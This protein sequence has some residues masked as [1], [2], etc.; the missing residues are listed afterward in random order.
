MQNELYHYGVPGM[1][2]GVRRY[3][4]ADGSLNKAGK[5]RQAYEDAKTELKT[6]DKDARKALQAL[7]KASRTSVGIKGTNK[8]NAA[9]KALKD[10]NETA[11][12]AY[13]DAVEKK[14]K[15]KA[16]TAKNAEKAEYKT[17]MYAMAKYGIRDSVMD[18]ASGGKSTAIYNKVKISKGKEYADRIER[19]LRNE[20]I[21]SF[22]THAAVAV[23]SIVV[24]AYSSSH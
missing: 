16:A 24:S 4:N 2:W 11:S 23:G 21:A 18:T 22:A 17:Y 6:A 1:K 15:L 13:V 3:T 12:R 20:A 9:K 5:A 14:A 7:R 10:A 19:R 8:Y